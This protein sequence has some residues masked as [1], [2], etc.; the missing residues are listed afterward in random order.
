MAS[1]LLFGSVPQAWPSLAAPAF[2]YGQLPSGSR[3]FN[4]MSPGMTMPT[5]APLANGGLPSTLAMPG[6]AGLLSGTDLAGGVSAPAMLAAIAVRR[7][8]PLGP[9]NDQE[10]EDFIGDALDLLPGSNDIDVR[11]DSGR[12]TLT[13]QVSHKRFKRDAGEIAWAIP[14][15]NDVQNNVTIVARRR[16]RTAGR[17]TETPVVAS[18]KQA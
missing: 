18:R 4:P 11:C 1:E 10:I 17:E 16:S 14:G 7:G 8:Q 12:I 15:V 9:T 6:V 5:S 2:A 3:A 13:G